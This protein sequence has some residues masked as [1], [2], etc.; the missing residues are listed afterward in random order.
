MRNIGEVKI[1]NNKTYADLHK[2]NNRLNNRLKKQAAA[3]KKLP[4]FKPDNITVKEFEYIGYLILALITTYFSAHLI[5]WI[6]N[7]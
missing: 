5:Y 2:I 1:M 6:L 3:D 4:K 7:K